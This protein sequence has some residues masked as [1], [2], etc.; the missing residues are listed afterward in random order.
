VPGTG[1]YYYK[2]P[3]SVGLVSTE[4]MVLMMDEMGIDS[5]VP[6]MGPAW[7]LPGAAS[8][9]QEQQQGAELV[10]AEATTEQH[11][12]EAAADPVGATQDDAS[13]QPR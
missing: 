2:D 7:L 10:A 9:P 4:D 13:S 11:T 3:N 6:K 5:K 1:S 12:T 8:E